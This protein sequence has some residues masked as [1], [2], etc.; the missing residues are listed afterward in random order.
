MLTMKKKKAGGGGPKHLH[1]RHARTKEEI[2]REEEEELRRL[3]GPRVADEDVSMVETVY[4]NDQLMAKMAQDQEKLR[5][6]RGPAEMSPRTKRMIEQTQTLDA[7]TADELRSMPE[8]APASAPATRHIKMRRSKSKTEE[9]PPPTSP[10]PPPPPADEAAQPR[11]RML[12]RR[13]AAPKAEATDAAQPARRRLM[14]S[15]AA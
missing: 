13:N 3:Y 8:A 5:Q 11:R 6:P 9:P 4:F 10:P 1:M 2:D 15:R 7:D 12:V 14:K